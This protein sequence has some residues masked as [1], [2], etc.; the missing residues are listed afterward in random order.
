MKEITL[1]T[2]GTV[3]FAFVCAMANALELKLQKKHES[4][5]F[6]ETLSQRCV[7]APLIDVVFDHAH[8]E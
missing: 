6:I 8:V 2:E 5:V 1:K 7:A 3:Q 4:N